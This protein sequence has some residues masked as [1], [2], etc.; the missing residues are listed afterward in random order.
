MIYIFKAHHVYIIRLQGQCHKNPACFIFM[1]DSNVTS[2]KLIDKHTANVTFKPQS[3]SKHSN[4]HVSSDIR[5]NICALPPE[6]YSSNTHRT[7]RAYAPCMDSLSRRRKLPS[8]PALERRSS[9]VDRVIL[10]WYHGWWEN[11]LSKGFS[12]PPYGDTQVILAPAVFKR[13]ST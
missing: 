11:I 7:Q 1:T 4:G 8:L 13:R 6:R 5:G 9:A 3:N 12:L 2:C 10:P